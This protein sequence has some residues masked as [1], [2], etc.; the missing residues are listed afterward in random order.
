MNWTYINILNNYNIMKSEITKVVALGEEIG[1]GHLM[2][3]ASALWRMKMISSGV[4]ISGVCIP[5]TND[6]IVKD[7][8]IQKI[9][10]DEIKL[11]DKIVSPSI[12]V[13]KQYFKE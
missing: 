7:N 3:L 9:V 2:S 10:N 13:S 8:D 12:S 5:V 6:M 11:Y 4:P 1:Y